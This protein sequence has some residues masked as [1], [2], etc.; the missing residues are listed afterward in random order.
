MPV[1]DHGLQLARGKRRKS[2]HLILCRPFRL[3][4]A[5]L[6]IS[7]IWAFPILDA[8]TEQSLALKLRD[9]GDVDAAHQLV[10]VSSSRMQNCDG[11]SGLRFARLADLISREYRVDEGGEEI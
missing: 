7:V 9:Q 3:K 4:A 8:D 2:C 1:V 11:V 5:C 6:S 10:L